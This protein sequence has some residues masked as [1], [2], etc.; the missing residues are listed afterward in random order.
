MLSGGARA[1]RT[2]T[3]ENFS[4]AIKIL[5]ATDVAGQGI[6]VEGI[7]HVVVQPTE[8]LKITSTESAEQAGLG[9][10]GVDQLCQRG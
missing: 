4:L 6:H 3:L 8:D 9:D 1:K 5:V 10:R 2:K 7:S